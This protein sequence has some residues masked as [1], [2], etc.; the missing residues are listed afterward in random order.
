VIEMRWE[1]ANAYCVWAGRSLP[2]EAQWEKAAKGT[3]GRIF[4]WGDE[5]PNETLLN[6]N[7][8][9]GETTRVGS[10]EDGKSPYGAYDMAGN[11]WEWVADKY[12]KYYYSNS[13]S[14]NPTGPD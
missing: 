14:E 5:N 8:N 4:P 13:P 7:R 2:T 1:D 9:V 10:Y 6:Y 11:V 3:D 12:N